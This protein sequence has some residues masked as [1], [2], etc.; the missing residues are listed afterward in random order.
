MATV[1]ATETFA[2]ESDR[3]YVV[4]KE[5][6]AFDSKDP[7]VKRFPDKFKSDEEPKRRGRPPVEQATAAP[8]ELRD[9]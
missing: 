7:M 2:A 3:G 4:V 6:Q 1:R 9:L 5:D 8:G